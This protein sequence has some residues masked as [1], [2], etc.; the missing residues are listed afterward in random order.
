MFKDKKKYLTK[1]NTTYNRVD[2]F[3]RMR[4]YLNKRIIVHKYR[5]T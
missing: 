4:T 1:E 5:L 3:C 2:T